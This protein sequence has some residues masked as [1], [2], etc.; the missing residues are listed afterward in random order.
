VEIEGAEEIVGLAVGK[1]RDP[2]GSIVGKCVGDGVL[3]DVGDVPAPK[4]NAKKKRSKATRKK[5]SPSTLI[6]LSDF[7]DFVDFECEKPNIAFISPSPSL[8]SRTV[9]WRSLL[10]L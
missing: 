8:R 1:E 10:L 2:T 3:G 7:D 6:S 9:F 4:N 5:V